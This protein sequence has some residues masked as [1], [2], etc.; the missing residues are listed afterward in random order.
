MSFPRKRE[1]RTSAVS[2]AST[3]PYRNAVPSLS[4]GLAALSLPKGG[5]P[6]VNEPN[7]CL[8]LKALHKRFFV[9]MSVPQ[10][11]FENSASLRLRERL[12]DL[13]D[14]GGR[15]WVPASGR[16]VHSVVNPPG[17]K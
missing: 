11:P 17:Q 6:W 2:T 14:L 9:K 15:N 12:V 16:A 5:L 4:P 13:D 1:S 10:T 8:T 7:A 3:C